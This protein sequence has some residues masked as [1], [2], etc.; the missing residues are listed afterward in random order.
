MHNKFVKVSIHSPLVLFHWIIGSSIKLK[1]RGIVIS[2]YDFNTV[3]TV[4][5]INVLMV[6]YSL[7]CNLLSSKGR[8]SI[9]IYRSSLYHLITIIKPV[10]SANNITDERLSYICKWL[11]ELMGN[12]TS[13][14]SEIKRPFSSNLRVGVNNFY[15]LQ[16]RTMSTLVCRTIF[17]NPKSLIKKHLI[18]NIHEMARRSKSTYSQDTTDLVL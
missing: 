7:H 8:T 18:L 17:T 13:S 3:N 1:E 11:Y 14:N 16:R 5:L 9:Y 2:I 15:S 10:L 4:K 12:V 6:K